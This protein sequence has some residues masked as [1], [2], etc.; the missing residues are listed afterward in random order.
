M[1]K[2]PQDNEPSIETLHGAL[3]ESCPV[4]AWGVGEN[5]EW[6]F[7]SLHP[8]PHGVEASPKIFNTAFLHADFTNPTQV[9]KILNDL[10]CPILSERRLPA[11]PFFRKAKTPVE[12]PGLHSNPPVLQ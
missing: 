4:V 5:P 10:F 1:P 6:Q 12:I 7:C 2:K 8:R 11:C 3:P 9:K